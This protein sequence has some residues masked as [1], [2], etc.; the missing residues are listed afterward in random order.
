MEPSLFVG[1]DW[2]PRM[3]HVWVTD[4][5]GQQVGARQVVN[6]AVGIADLLAWLMALGAHAPGQ[7]A[8]ALEM[9]HG[10]IIDAALERGCQVF[11]LNPKQVDRFRDRFSVAGAKDDSRDAEV[12]SSALRTDRHVFRALE[13]EDPLTVE[14]RELSRQDTELAEDITRLTNRLRD[15]L[16]RT[17]PELLTLVPAA[18][19]PWLWDLLHRAPT[20]AEATRLRQPQI[21]RILS[22]HHIRRLTLADIVPVLRTP[23]VALAAGLREGVRVRILDLVEQLPVLD[24]QRRT[25]LRRLTVTLRA[26]ADETTTPEIT[27]EQ[28]DVV[29]LQSLPGIGTR[30]AATLLAEAADPLRRRD[31]HAL[32]QLG[33]VAPVTKRSGKTCVVRFRYAC[34]GRVRTAIYLWVRVATQRDPR[35]RAHYTALRRA[36][37]SHARAL[38]GV[39]DRL[40]AMLIAMLRTRTPYDI[41]RRTRAEAA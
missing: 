31:Y 11:V 20:A 30:I 1:V 29:I 2:G 32:R 3:H 4:G 39:A 33:G 12:L 41:T 9:P 25:M 36:G 13:I 19:E 6:T 14:L 38:R 23:S 34:H 24:R 8:I 17:W 16:L 28:T 5:T 22:R 27:R 26:I 40:L 7:V 15:H 18:D 37:H 10:P 21:Q 35:S